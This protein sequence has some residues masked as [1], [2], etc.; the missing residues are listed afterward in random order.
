MK[1]F[2]NN[3]RRESVFL[4]AWAIFTCTIIV[5]VTFLKNQDG[6]EPIG[7]ATKIIRILSYGLCAVLILRHSYTR[8]S[9]LCIA[10]AAGIILISTLMSS[11]TVMVWCILFIV[12][13]MDVDIDKIFGVSVIFRIIM[14]GGTLALTCAGVIE[15]YVFSASTRARHGLGFDW[16]TTGPILFLFLSLTYICVRKENLKIIELAVIE[17]IH[18]IFYH[19]TDTNMTFYMGTLSVIIFLCSIL[20][21]KKWY[22]TERLGY[23]ICFAPTVIGILA[24]LLHVSYDG[25][26]AVWA[27]LNNLMSGRLSLGY[28]A[29]RTYGLTL[30]G[31]NIEWVGFGIDESGVGYNYVDCSYLQY[32]L[33]YGVIFLVLVLTIYTLI[34]YR[35]V[36]H[37]N[38]YLVWACLIT[39]VFSVTE[40]WLFNFT[41]NPIPIAVLAKMKDRND[42]RDEILTYEEECKNCCS[43]TQAVSD[44]QG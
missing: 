22:I 6:Y 32:M 35:A 15:D 7:M 3:T 40:P 25:S 37:K 16:A 44:A 10:V 14:I 30:F 31:Q 5:G 8:K 27:K 12:A 26:N 17:V 38:Y 34:I 41:F 29:F 20:V 39:L 19:Y 4:I 11:N 18:C 36:K 28:D 9:I 24:I 1:L 21:K 2:K 13:A 33:E 43:D 23:L 42:E